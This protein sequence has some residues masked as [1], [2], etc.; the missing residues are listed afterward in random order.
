MNGLHFLLQWG[1]TF[2]AA[3]GLGIVLLR[4]ALKYAPGAILSAIGWV[5]LFTDGQGGV[6]HSRGDLKARG[7]QSLGLWAARA[8][9]RVTEEDWRKLANGSR[10]QLEAFRKW[11]ERRAARARLT[12]RAG[13]KVAGLFFVW[14]AKE[15]WEEIIEARDWIAARWPFNRRQRNVAAGFARLQTVMGADMPSALDE[16]TRQLAELESLPMR[17][18]S[19][20]D[21]GRWTRWAAVHRVLAERGHPIDE[22]LASAAARAPD[23]SQARGLLGSVIAAKALGVLSPKLAGYLLL[24]SLAANAAFA[25]AWKFEQHQA[26][27]ARALVNAPCSIFERSEHSE[28]KREACV[29]LGQVERANTALVVK[30]NDAA[31]AKEAAAAENN[32]KIVV[33]AATAK[34]DVAKQKAKRLANVAKPK[35]PAAPAAGVDPALLPPDD[36][37]RLNLFAPPA[38]GADSAGDARRADQGSGPVP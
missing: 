12:L 3:F 13:L 38:G 26:N 31:R 24:G 35:P 16:Y 6:K 5:S 33:R 36:L 8:M 25:T 17:K 29:A 34:T 22:K 15:V 11:S 19:K 20:E 14:M 27:E 18:W 23:M 2:A 1:E 4:T 28:T 37:L 30:Y 10:E 32:T 9:G 21:P 7:V